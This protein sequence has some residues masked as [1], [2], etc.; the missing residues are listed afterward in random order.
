MKRGSSLAQVGGGNTRLKGKLEAQ[1]SPL[2]LPST[3]KA[4]TVKAGWYILA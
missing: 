1:S 3:T 4:T 2:I